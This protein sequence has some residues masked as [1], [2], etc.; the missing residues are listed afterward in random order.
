MDDSASKPIGVKI[1]EL[2]AGKYLVEACIGIG[3]MGAVVAARHTELGARVA[4]KVLLPQMAEDPEAIAR[5]SREAR[6]MFNL[7]SEHAAKVLDV[8]R[9]P[10]GGP[11][12]VMEYLSGSDLAT[13]LGQR[14]HFTPMEAA[15]LVLQA[16][17]AVAEA[18]SLGIVH[19]DLKPQNLF[20]TTRV[21]GAASV[22]VLDFGISKMPLGNGEQMNITHSSAVMGT[23]L[24]M[25]PEQLHSSASADS[26]SDIWAIGVVL[27][28]LLTGHVPFDAPSAPALYALMLSSTPKPPNE[29]LL[30]IPAELSLVVMRCLERDR[31]K[32]FPNV[33]ALAAALER[34][35]PDSMSGAGVRLQAV[36]DRSSER[37]DPDGLNETQEATAVPTQ[38]TWEDS[39]NRRKRKRNVTVSVV[40]VALAVAIGAFV[41]TSAI[42]ARS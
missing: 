5:F 40:G 12:M 9:L 23:P 35:A 3:G 33:A 14:G 41:A 7:R 36:H 42:R 39:T 8:G 34:F 24:Y 17:E 27:Y 2:I 6:A 10:N 21:D 4:I 30:E 28:E 38:A 32:R 25:S 31:E 18:H 15:H 37:R 26:R 22:K 19:R 13:V 20:L 16:C 1:G 11:F 29:I